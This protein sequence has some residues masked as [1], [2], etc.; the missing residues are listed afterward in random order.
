M[1][2]TEARVLE[3]LN[4]SGRLVLKLEL[5]SGDLRSGEVL[6][7][8]TGG[9]VQIV[10]IGFSPPDAWRQGVRLATVNHLGGDE[11]LPGAYLL[12]EPDAPSDF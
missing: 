5:I 6:K 4:A 2:R 1:M 7:S 11:P 3:V 10:G 12:G 8:S 9:V